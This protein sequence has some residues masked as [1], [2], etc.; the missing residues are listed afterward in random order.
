ML[1]PFPRVLTMCI[2]AGELR[3]KLDETLSAEKKSSSSKADVSNALRA[4]IYSN[5]V[6]PLEEWVKTFHK[7]K[8]VKVSY[9]LAHEGARIP[10]CIEASQDSIFFITRAE[11]SSTEGL[12]KNGSTIRMKDV[13]R[14]K[15]KI[16][17]ASPSF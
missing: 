14:E 1:S 6:S 16:Y 11:T 2:M 5:V 13:D 12:N 10:L 7:P 17:P 8:T 9:K 4:V 15:C 3:R